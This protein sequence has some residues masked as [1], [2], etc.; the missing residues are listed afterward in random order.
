MGVNQ[1]QA[2]H[3]QSEAVDSALGGS[4][5][6]GCR[7]AHACSGPLPPLALLPAPPS[8]ASTDTQCPQHEHNTGV[9]CRRLAMLVSSRIGRLLHVRPVIA[10]R[11]YCRAHC[12]HRNRPP[13]LRIARIR[14]QVPL[15]LR[16]APTRKCK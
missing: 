1:H 5:R 7:A 9:S 13:R 4:G 10:N 3:Q 12:T 2:V 11:G 15:T 16:R 6:Y 8:P 14:A